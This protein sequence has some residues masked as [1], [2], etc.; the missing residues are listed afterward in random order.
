M[1]LFTRL[2]VTDRENRVDDIDGGGVLLYLMKG[3]EL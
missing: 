3:E 1:S 2:Y